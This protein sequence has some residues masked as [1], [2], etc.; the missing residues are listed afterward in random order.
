MTRKDSDPAYRHWPERLVMTDPQTPATGYLPGM[1]HG[2]GG[3]RLDPQTPATL[4]QRLE[5]MM[6]RGQTP[7]TERLPNIDGHCEYWYQE[8]RADAL[9]E[10]AERVRALDDDE[11]YIVR[12]VLAI[13]DPHE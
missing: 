11:G 4:G 13:L 9:R 5:E 6:D 8:G 2:T 12:A 1:T 10:A 7:A 3:N